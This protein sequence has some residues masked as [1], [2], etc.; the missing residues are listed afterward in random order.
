MMISADGMRWS[1]ETF[2]DAYGFARVDHLDPPECVE[3]AAIR[4]ETIT[5]NGQ[6]MPARYASE[7]D[8]HDVIAFKGLKLTPGGDPCRCCG[9][10]S[11]NVDDDIC[12][13]CIDGCFDDG[14]GC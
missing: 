1:L 14:M 2:L 4:V 13:D 9:R 6:L 3:A 8:W 12:V 10:T 7:V 11:L 5:S